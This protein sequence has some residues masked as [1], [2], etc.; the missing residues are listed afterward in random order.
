[1]DSFLLKVVKSVF[2]EEIK[3]QNFVFVLPNQRAGV[4][5]KK[6][7]TNQLQQTSLFPEI[8]TFDNFVEKTTGIT[9]CS[10]L[11]LLIDFYQVYK[12]HTPIDQIE[13][14]ELFSNWAT[15]VLDDF[16]EIDA[17]LVDPKALFPSLKEINE[18]HNWNPNTELT[19]NYLVFFQN[20][21]KYYYTFYDKLVGEERGYQGLIF[22]QA[23]DSI[24]SFIDNTKNQYV[25]V[26]FN[27]LKTSESQ[28]IQELL[29]ADK[30]HIYWDISENL[31]KEPHPAG[32]FIR[33]YQSEWN[34]YKNNKFNWISNNEIPTSTIEIIGVSKNVG[35]LKYAGELLQNTKDIDETALVLADQNLLPIVLNTLPRKIE[36]VN[37]TMGFPLRNF[38]FTD[39]VDCIFQLYTTTNTQDNKLFYYKQ[40]MRLL[41]HPIIQT[42]FSHVDDLVAFL[43]DKNSI[44][45]SYN[46]IKKYCEIQ[47][48]DD[49]EDVLNLFKPIKTDFFQDILARIALLIAVLKT[50]LKGIE[51]EVLYRHFQL[52]QQIF[53]LYEKHKELMELPKGQE[54]IKSLYKI[55]KKLLFSES[56]SF[57]GEPLQGL[58]IMGFLETQALGFKQVILISLNE[59]ILPKGK[60]TNSFI[61][62]DV[63]KHFG[64]LT[65]K[66]E[67]A[68]ASYHFYRLLEVAD[69]VS[70]LYNNQTDTFGGGEKSQFLT[71]LLWQ[72]PTIKQSFI[73]PNTSHE[74]IDLQSL[75][76]TP[77]IIEKLK[78]IAIKGFSP[79]A[80]AT[81]IYNPI[82]FYQQRI[83][84]IKDLDEIEETVAD[85]TLGT[86]IHETLEKLYKP[87]IG[88][89]LNEEVLQKLLPKIPEQIK[90]EFKKVYKNG[91]FEQGKNKLIYEVILN[92]IKRF[93]KEE[94]SLVK[95]GKTIKIVA[96]ELPLETE[97]HFPK[98]DFPIKIKGYID[99]IDEVDGVVRILDFKSGKVDASQLRMDD[100]SKISSD[101][102]Y[103]K[104]LQ[105]L[106]YAY[107]YKQH[108]NY[109]TSKELQAG[110]VSFKNLNAG[111]IP[112]NFAA[113]RAKAEYQITTS[114]F[115]SFMGS[116]ETLLLEIFDPN[117]PFKERE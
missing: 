57:I 92:F 77:A 81:Y 58:Q 30:A 68:I 98:F 26:G 10:A 71:Q 41:Q 22:R 117:I 87:L 80:L 38:P 7:I 51:K 78:E 115:D 55:Y 2:K 11:E 110:I 18:I 34:Y 44:Y 62:F 27:H 46:D 85:N 3:L 109:D 8:L 75:V 89:F 14:F 43:V 36:K 65:Y 5:L 39:L 103:S 54:G 106:L 82:E 23:V 83:L 67:D 49:F 108:K 53:L 15:T 9:K 45:H 42:H 61:P 86:V 91:Q 74:N 21:E 37:I 66:E 90:I 76:K 52:N 32:Q 112:V 16:N 111:F 96:L 50:K 31:L 25:F 33:N 59:G 47:G 12:E 60:R 13:S 19:K 17:Y 95:S 116:V 63:R 93:I 72:Y 100:F 56:F 104:A 35:M 79:S 105:I 114:H 64:L 20:L 70:L 88:S 40:V 4:Y 84:K 24:H 102:K 29:A 1:M 6:H 113:P 48:I 28:I 73:N 99:R 101:Y 97:I 107:L 94:I 69:K